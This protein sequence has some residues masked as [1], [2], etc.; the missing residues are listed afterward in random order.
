MW[1]GV[2]ITGIWIG[3]GMIGWK[4]PGAGVCAA[5]FGMIATVVIA[6]A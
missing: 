2:A 3:I 5:I 6:H 1:K 4:E